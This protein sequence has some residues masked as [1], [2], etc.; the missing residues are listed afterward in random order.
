MATIFITGSNGLIGKALCEQLKDSAYQI[1]R[2]DINLPSN[3][4]DYGDINHTELIDRHL[5]DC[6]GIV[7]LAAVSRVVWGQQQPELCWQTNVVGT[8]HILEYAYQSPRKPWLLY[9]SSREVYGEQQQ[10]PVTESALL[11]PVNIYARSKVAAETIV[12][13]YQA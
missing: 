13:Q 2:L 12:N 9:A 10:L 4:P 8:A 6:D 11:S 1:K 5:E 3:H 7:H